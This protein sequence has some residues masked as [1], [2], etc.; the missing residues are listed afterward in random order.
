MPEFSKPTLEYFE[1]LPL[2][3]VFGAACLGVLVEAFLPREQRRLPQVL[4]DPRSAWRP[5]SAA[6]IWIATDLEEHA[7]TA[8]PAAWSA[9]RAAS[10]STARPSTC[11]A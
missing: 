9:P 8:P 4:R 2:F 11:G 7:G 6:T 1:L 10:S 5:R 3:I